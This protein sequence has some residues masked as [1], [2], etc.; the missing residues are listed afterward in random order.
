MVLN[1]TQNLRIN[2]KIPNEQEFANLVLKIG[3]GEI[4]TDENDNINFS[5]EYLV[6]NLDNLISSIWPN[7][8]LESLNDSVILAAKNEDVDFINNYVLNLINEPEFIYY[9]A[10]T[11]CNNLIS[12]DYPTD[13]LNSLNFGSFPNHKLIL[14]KNVPV[15]LLRNLCPTLGL[16][17]GTRLICKSFH[18]HVIE[19][20]I[21]TGSFKGQKVFLPRISLIP[22]DCAIEFKRRQFPI[23]LAMSMTIN[24]SQGQTLKHVGLFLKK[25]VFSHGQLYVA[26]SRVTSKSNVKVFLGNTTFTK[27]IVYP[28]ALL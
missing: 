7:F 19:A 8:D 27:N 14:K 17:N 12:T 13:F 25:P 10:D 3:N 20:E 1:L 6:P 11:L 24:K 23:K 4:E 5:T 28:E 16:C 22:Q 18:Q 26:L 15:I 9:S 21:A 2:S